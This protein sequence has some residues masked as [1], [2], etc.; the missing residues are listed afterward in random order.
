MMSAMTIEMTA[1]DIA[2]V[3]GFVRRWEKAGG[4]ERANYQMFFAE[5]CDAL[6][7]STISPIGSELKAKPRD[8]RPSHWPVGR[9]SPIT[10]SPIRTELEEQ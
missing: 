2:R 3:E 9:T 1:A 6:G 4:K 8:N 7:R 5:M 10:S